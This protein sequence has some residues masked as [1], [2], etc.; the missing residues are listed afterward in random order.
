MQN[1]SQRSNDHTHRDPITGEPGAHPL[2]TGL[3]AA[4][5]GAA[6]GAVAGTVAGPVGTALGAAAGAIAGG[7]VGKAAAEEIDPTQP[8][9]YWREHYASRWYVVGDSA[10]ED[11]A[12]AYEYGSES[13]LQFVGR[14]FDDVESELVRNWEAVRGNSSLAWERARHAVRDAWNRVRQS[15]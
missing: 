10:Y 1:P 3:G 2:G 7:L 8:H 14:E 5:G 15:I 9:D 4:V 12:S 13:A 11:Y 6:A